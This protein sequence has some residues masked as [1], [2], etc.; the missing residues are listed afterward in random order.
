GH[1][2]N[3]GAGTITANYDGVKK[4][5]T[6]IGDRTKTGSNSVFVAPVTVGEDVTVAAGSVVTKDVE[7]DCLVVARAKQSTIPGWRSQRYANSEDST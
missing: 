6:V 2:V 3:I 5:P 7:N 4:H 1:Q